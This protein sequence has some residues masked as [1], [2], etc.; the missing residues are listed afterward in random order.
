MLEVDGVDVGAEDVR[1]A[2]QPLRRCVT[3]FLKKE[4]LLLS[5][6][7]P[8]LV[9]SLPIVTPESISLQVRVGRI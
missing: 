1:T 6:A 2:S 9:V 5:N 8:D 3:T 4:D 7:Q